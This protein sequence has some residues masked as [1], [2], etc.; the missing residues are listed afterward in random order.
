MTSSGRTGIDT[1][2]KLNFYGKFIYIRANYR[3][4]K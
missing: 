1:E 4:G 3:F 2:L